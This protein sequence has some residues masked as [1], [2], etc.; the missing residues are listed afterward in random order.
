M[1]EQAAIS[2]VPAAPGRAQSETKL[3]LPASKSMRRD[4]VITWEYYGATGF[5]AHA[6][7]FLRPSK[8]HSYPVAYAGA[9]READVRLSYD[10]DGPALWLKHAQFPLIA[11]EAAEVERVLGPLGLR[12][13]RDEKVPI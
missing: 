10:S 1:I 8:H 9:H 7:A 13:E 2:A 3:R 5:F 11:T 4:L 6:H 12:I